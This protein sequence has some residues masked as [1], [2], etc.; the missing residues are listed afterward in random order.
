MALYHYTTEKRHNAII[1]SGEFYPSDNI[2][3]DSVYGVGWYFTDLPPDTC[4][5]I[6]MRYCWERSTLHQ[7][8]K[9][10]LQLEVVGGEAKWKRADVYFVRKSP[11]VSFK[12]VKHGKTPECTLKPCYSC[13]IN[14]EK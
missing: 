2:Q 6:L 11:L 3:T 1:S 4:E 12:I 13:D 9:Y 14:P 8:V 5:K 10:Y 7:R